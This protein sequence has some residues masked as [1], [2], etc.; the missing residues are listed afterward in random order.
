MQSLWIIA[1]IVLL[2]FLVYY[3]GLQTIRDDDEL[4]KRFNGKYVDILSLGIV[5]LLTTFSKNIDPRTRKES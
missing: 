4:H 3:V 5:T 2:L 1:C